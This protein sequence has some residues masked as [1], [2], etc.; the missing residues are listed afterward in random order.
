MD[1][2]HFYLSFKGIEVVSLILSTVTGSGS[3]LLVYATTGA[4]VFFVCVFF[5]LGCIL[6]FI[7]H[8]ILLFLFCQKSLQ[9]CN[10]CQIKSKYLSLVDS[11]FSISEVNITSRKI[12]V[13]MHLQTPKQ[14]WKN[15]D[16][17]MLLF[18]NSYNR[19]FSK[20]SANCRVKSK[21]FQT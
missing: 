4:V 19:L 9:M 11:I 15:E 12:V 1:S 5:Y 20:S 3:V 6:F 18:C 14:Q 17:G 8:F 21:K 10:S 7:F 2:K 13:M 16:T